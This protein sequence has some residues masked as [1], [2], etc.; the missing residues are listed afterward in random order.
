MKF[1]LDIVILALILLTTFVGYKKGFLHIALHLCGFVIALV[2]SLLLYQPLSNIII[3]YTP[4]TTQIETQV[5]SRLASTTQEEKSTVFSQYYKNFKNTSTSVVAH[6]VSVSII[7]IVTA[8]LLFF[9][10]RII[11]LFIKLSG[12]FLDK[13]PLIRQVNHAAG[14]IYG[15]FLGF[16]IVYAVFTVVAIL[17]PLADIS[18]LLS[19]IN[20]SIIGNIMY[21]NNIIFMFLV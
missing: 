11:L 20:H 9:V 1:I 14:F 15:V 17:A 3:K 19:M 8:L 18:S 10:I 16:M 2:I 7:H 21:N 5:E 4:L 6:S 12:D 13:L